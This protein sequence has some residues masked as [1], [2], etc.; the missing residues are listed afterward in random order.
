MI[1]EYTL[2]P[3]LQYVPLWGI[4]FI[5]ALH[6]AAQRSS[7]KWPLPVTHIF[8]LEAPKGPGGEFINWFS[9][10]LS[11]LPSSLFPSLPPWKCWF[12]PPQP[13]W[14]NQACGLCEPCLN[15]DGLPA[16]FHSPPYTPSFAPFLDKF[17]VLLAQTLF[18]FWNGKK[19]KTELSI[20]APAA[21]VSN[22]SL[23]VCVFSLYCIHKYKSSPGRQN[24]QL[25]FPSLLLC[26]STTFFE[27]VT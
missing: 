9:L 8:W 16:I 15:S 26:L 10:L 27:D 3:W 5:G 17:K 19:K 24:W 20:R 6:A 2:N 14:Q 13:S 23:C 21:I 4:K 1:D 25:N 7:T 11:L 18:N 12:T 22:L